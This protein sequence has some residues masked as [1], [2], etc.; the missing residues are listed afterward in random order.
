MRVLHLYAGNLFGGV[1]TFLATMARLRTLSAMQPTFG[2]CFEGRLSDE[3]KESGAAV[4][5][6][7]SA[8]FS[9]PWSVLSCRRSLRRML[10]RERFDVAICHS[11]WPHALFAPAIRNASVPLVFW[12]HNPPADHWVDRRAARTAPD[13]LVAN[14]RFTLASYK[15]WFTGCPRIELRMPVAPVEIADRDDTRRNVRLELQTRED[16]VVIACTSRLEPWKGQRLLLESLVKL[17]GLPNW[18]AWIAGGPQRES[19]RKYLAELCAQAFASGLESRVE[20]V[21]P[22]TDVPRVL[23]AADIHCQPNTG[24]EPFGIAFVE[25]LYA[26]LPVISTRM[27]GAEEIVNDECGILVSPNADELADALRRL[28]DQPALRARLGAGG[29]RR[30][31][32]LCDPRVAMPNI[33]QELSKV[34]E[35]K[36]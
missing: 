19:E 14:S 4:E 11:A 23:A 10:A 7:G 32:E 28:I 30:A 27:G 24:P 3:L 17:K 1:E 34:I 13:L 6:L 29:P 20:F 2:L 35:A 5:I 22:R 36:K 12:A 21:G 25:A 16:D 8:R 18:S 31:A 26:G 9:R 33:E 15:S